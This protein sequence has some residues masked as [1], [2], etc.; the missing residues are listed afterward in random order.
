MTSD[1]VLS[2]DGRYRYWLSRR[3]AA[4]SLAT[5]VMLNPS[6]ADA[7]IDDPTIR[8]CAGFAKAWGLAGIVVV[9]LYALRATDPR[10][11]W[12]VGPSEA[13]G[14]QNDEHLR[15]AAQVAY[16]HESPLV[17]AWGSNAKPGRVAWVC[18]MPHMDR[19]T[20]LGT[21]KG[22]A[23]RHPLYLRSDAALASWNQP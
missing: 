6:T 2:N 17:A 18:E 1:A 3:W 11:L 5:F 7:E 10:R 15:A 22:G 19:L 23:P 13:V 21:T 14:P 12:K 4:G 16:A 20:A 8:R 9:N